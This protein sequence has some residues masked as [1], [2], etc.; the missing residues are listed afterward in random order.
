VDTL[1]LVDAA[2]KEAP[3][4]RA[5]LKIVLEAAIDFFRAALRCDA[6]DAPPPD[7]LV[8]RAIG[9]WRGTAE[10]AAMGLRHSLQA[11]EAVDRNAHL[12][13]L[14]DAWTTQLEQ[15]VQPTPAAPRS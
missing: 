2:G 9:A 11:S 12:P 3:P 15:I 5:R 7:A 13:T 14:V 6:G 10:E 1:A 8:A 4:R